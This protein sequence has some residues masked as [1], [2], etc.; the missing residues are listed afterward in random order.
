MVVL[1]G[2]AWYS[3]STKIFIFSWHNFCLFFF[4][5]M[6]ILQFY[7][8]IWDFFDFFW[9]N[10]LSFLH[11]TSTKRCRLTFSI[12]FCRLKLDISYLSLSLSCGYKCYNPKF[13]KNANLS[14]QDFSSGH[15]DQR[16]KATC[17]PTH[18]KPPPFSKEK[19]ILA[20]HF[21]FWIRLIYA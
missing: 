17:S 11:L 4:Q 20:N 5:F 19:K 10:F 15:V 18:P 16:S 1:T 8:T 2:T 9:Q 3:L 21:L 7:S 12:K 14:K 6:S 13:S